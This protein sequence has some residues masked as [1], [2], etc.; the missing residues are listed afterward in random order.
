MA[1]L[2]VLREALKTVAEEL[3][4][5]PAS[6]EEIKATAIS[7]SGIVYAGDSGSGLAYVHNGS[8]WSEAEPEMFSPVFNINILELAE[9]VRKHGKTALSEGKNK[10]VIRRKSVVPADERELVIWN[11][12]F[13]FMRGQWLLH[14]VTKDFGYEIPTGINPDKAQ[15]IPH[16]EGSDLEDPASTTFNPLDIE[17]DGLSIDQLS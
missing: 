7:G 11:C 4:I 8:G 16:D 1:E 13:H 14:Q 10:L 5:D 12:E 15:V 2:V 9:E 17:D 6:L 3:F